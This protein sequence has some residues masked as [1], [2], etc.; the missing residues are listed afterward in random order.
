MTIQVTTGNPLAIKKTRTYNSFSALEAQVV[1]VR[2]YQG[3][4]FRFADTISS[5]GQRVAEYVHDHALL[6]ISN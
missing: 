5:L 3:L 4:H 2:V 6:P 1:T